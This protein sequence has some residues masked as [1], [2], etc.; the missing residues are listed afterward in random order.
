MDG[1]TISTLDGPPLPTF[2]EDHVNIKALVGNTCT[3]KKT[4]RGGTRGR[5]STDA[6]NI[7][8]RSP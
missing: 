4:E 3:G 7:L 5:K 1:E 6:D 8:P 2:P